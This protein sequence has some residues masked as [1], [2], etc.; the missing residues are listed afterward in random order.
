MNDKVAVFGQRRAS[1]YLLSEIYNPDNIK[2]SVQNVGTVIPAVGSIVVDDSI[3]EH[4]RLYVVYSVDPT[5]YKSVLVPASLAELSDLSDDQVITY[6]NNIYM[7]Y[8]R[9]VPMN[10][11]I[12]WE[13][14]VDNKISIFGDKASTFSIYRGNMVT[15][16]SGNEAVV[17]NAYIDVDAYGNKHLIK[18][19]ACPMDHIVAP[20][21]DTTGTPT[22]VNAAIP[23]TCYSEDEIKSGDHLIFAVYDE[24]NRMIAQIAMIAHD[25]LGLSILA[26]Q[27]HPV[28]SFTISANQLDAEDNYCY[29]Y[30]GQSVD[31]LHFYASVL[32]SNGDSV[33]SAEIDNTKLFVYG[34]EDINTSIP[35]GVYKVTFKYFLDNHEVS[36]E[37]KDYRVGDTGRFIVT[38]KMVKI[39]S[40]IATKISKAALMLNYDGVNHFRPATVLYY[41]D[42]SQPALCTDEGWLVTPFDSTGYTNAQIVKIKVDEYLTDGSDVAT[43][44]FKTYQVNLFN[45]SIVH[46]TNGVFYYFR[47]EP[48]TTG[49]YY[50]KNTPSVP[51]PKIYYQQSLGGNATCVI[52]KTLFT[53]K[54]V[55]LSA[56]YYNAC[57]PKLPKSETDDLYEL[58]VPTHFQIRKLDLENNDISVL[59][60]APIAV[61][62]YM[63][64]LSLTSAIG[65]VGDNNYFNTVIVEFLNYNGTSYEYLFGVPVDVINAVMPPDPEPEPEPEPPEDDPIVWMGKINVNATNLWRRSGS[66]LLRGGNIHGINDGIWFGV[67]DFTFDD[68]TGI[69]EVG[70]EIRAVPKS[71][72]EDGYVA[73]LITAYNQRSIPIP[74]NDTYFMLFADADGSISDI[75]YSLSYNGPW[76]HEHDGAMH[77]ADGSEYETITSNEILDRVDPLSTFDQ[78]DI[79]WFRENYMNEH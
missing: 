61:E 30:R 49:T 7:V 62:N 15:E 58:V 39:I 4:N 41:K 20:T 75:W 67:G 10:G 17:S 25:T 45:P 76:F 63:D 5:T 24:D 42:R 54:E 12:Y 29:L 9:Q 6:G 21:T 28:E 56:F 52:P 69:S 34:I 66:L 59:S 65:P 74:S 57:P 18:S 35:G 51:R 48:S 47:D 22:L 3:G 16:S 23:R 78:E 44:Y 60:P 77:P 64:N 68:G 26:G 71:S 32:Y 72:D 73:K 27:Q 11:K 43:P 46:E 70:I 38:E 14:V 33:A 40:P 8:F 2:S 37:G 19:N 31:E 36:L 50:G 1:V 55:F 53:T 13:L 79:E